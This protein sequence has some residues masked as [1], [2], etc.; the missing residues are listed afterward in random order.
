MMIHIGGDMMV[1][2]CI[3]RVR[4]CNC[5]GLIVFGVEM[6]RQ[7]VALFRSIGLPFVIVDNYFIDED[8]DMVSINNRLGIRKSVR[9]LAKM[10]HAKIGYIKSKAV[11]NSFTERFDTYLGI[12]RELDLD[13]DD[14]YVYE[15]QYSENG[16]ATDMKKLLEGKPS[17]PTALIADNDLL[18]FGAMKALQE[19]GYR[20]PEDVSIIG[21]DDR[22]VCLMSEPNL[23]TVAI[24]KDSFGP[25]SVM[26]LLSRFETPRK[27]SFRIE[28]GVELIERDSVRR[29]ER[30]GCIG[31]ESKV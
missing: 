30:S 5:D 6:F 12:L 24:P 9:Y 29:I 31:Q 15:L 27:N 17:L 23:T 16:S 2:E 20:I 19:C 28:V 1:D 25:A 22:P 18:A 3:Q 10:G 7:D 21:F 11:I 8:V 26:L 4:N 14:R 13:F